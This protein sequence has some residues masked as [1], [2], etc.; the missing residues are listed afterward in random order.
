[1]GNALLLLQLG[2]Q[3]T[4]RLQELQLLIQ[5][6]S[7]ENRDVTDEE[8][9]AFADQAGLSGLALDTAIARAKSEGR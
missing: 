7:G 1:M 3:L 2:L 8:V 4:A 9:Q 6:A 5:K